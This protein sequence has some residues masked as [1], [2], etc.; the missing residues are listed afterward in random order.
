MNISL[1]SCLSECSAYLNTLEALLLNLSMMTI[2]SMLLV[3]QPRMWGM[4]TWY[5][6]PPVSPTRPTHCSALP[7]IT[8]S[9]W[10]R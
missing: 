7:A 10:S 3:R 5:W 1:I 6:P 9:C 2:S 4:L 8:V